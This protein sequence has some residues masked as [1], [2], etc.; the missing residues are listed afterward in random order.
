[1][2]DLGSIHGRLRGPLGACLA[3]GTTAC[4]A[5]GPPLRA[6]LPELQAR[7]AFDLGCP[8]AQLQ[9]AHLG[10]RSKGV[11]G[12][13]RRLSYV[14]RCGARQQGCAWTLDTPTAAQALWPEHALALERRQAPPAVVCAP[15]PVSPPCATVPT[16]SGFP[17]P[18]AAAAP[19]AGGTGPGSEVV[20]PWRD[21]RG[22][23]RGF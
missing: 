11:F 7:A 2:R 12:C 18:P 3:L 19:P 6:T 9:L 14:E 20:D 21:D 1:V 16:P 22:R 4:V 13:G 10:P 5:P 17:S 8:A 15:A 23:D